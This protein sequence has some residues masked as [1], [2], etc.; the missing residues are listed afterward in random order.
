MVVITGPL[1]AANDPVYKN[2]RMN[3]TVRC[4]LQFWKVCVL[5]RKDG[6]PSA[7]AF[8]LGQEEIADLPGFQETFDVAAT[9]IAITDLE[10]QTGLDF[11][12]LRKHDHF[13]EG[14]AP[15]TLERVPGTT[16]AT[17]GGHVIRD[18][19]DIVV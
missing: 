14:G 16:T 18:L 2:D 17:K 3:Y 11:G 9:Q 7:T 15:G 10:K 6:T 8:V 12:D 13:A 4:P 5:I 1:F 19:A